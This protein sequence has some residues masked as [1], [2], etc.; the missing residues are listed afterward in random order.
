MTAWTK[1][2]DATIT[3]RLK[4]MIVFK[5]KIYG[6]SDVGGSNLLEWNGVNAWSLAAPSVFGSVAGLTI[7]NNELYS[8]FGGKLYKW[9]EISAWVQI[10]TGTISGSQPEWIYA[11]DG[12]I[13]T[14]INE[15]YEWPGSGT[16]LNIVSSPPIPSFEHGLA[17]DDGSGESIWVG[18]GGGELYRWDGVSAFSLKAPPFGGGDIIS[19]MFIFEGEL[20]CTYANSAKLLKYNDAGSWVEMNPGSFSFYCVDAIA[21]GGVIYGIGLYTN[22]LYKINDSWLWEEVTSLGTTELTN[23]F[24][25]IGFNNKIYATGYKA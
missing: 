14:G 16:A 12:K 1:V 19:S 4:Y 3:N 6:I 13:Y 11:W 8:L 17:Y 7:H 18:N 9:D 5:G 24:T 25:L 10:T 22:K 21:Y 2:A 15:L 23:L 20:Y